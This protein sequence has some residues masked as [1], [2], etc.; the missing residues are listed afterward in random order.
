MPEALI[1]GVKL[2]Y[3]IHGEGFPLVWCHEFAADYRSWKAQVKFF[4]RQFRVVVYNARGYP[5]SDVPIH[6]GSYT[7]EQAMEDLRGL[8]DYLH[9]IQAHIGGH[10]MGG[11]VALTFAL[12]YPQMVRSLILAGTG[13]GSNNPEFFRRRIDEF[14]RRL[15]A[16][17]TTSLADYGNG[18]QRIQL[19]RKNP[20][21]WQTFNTHLLQQSNIGLA[22]TLRGIQG[23]RPSLFSLETE[24]RLFDVPTLIVLGDEDDPCIEPSLFLKRCISRSGLAVFPQTGHTVNMEEPDLFNETVLNF[25]R[26]VDADNWPR[27]DMGI[28]SAALVP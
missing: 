16:N 23:K 27:R 1:N 6:L 19:L 4:S 3:E 26:A 5:P 28:P 11:S 17:G 8:I 9:I 13:T 14:A 15:E 12:K 18:P 24:L 2:Y 21:T 20:K 7:Q 10:S 22:L 25:L